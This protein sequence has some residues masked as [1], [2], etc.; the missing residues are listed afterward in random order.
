MTISLPSELE[1]LIE[2]RIQSGRYHSAVEVIVDALHLLR[3]RDEQDEQKRENLR[4]D[5][6]A[7]LEQIN[8]GK[9]GPLNA[10]ET[11]ARIRQE[12][13]SGCEG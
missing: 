7:G 5:L 9:V 8:Q 13:I 10:K 12:R 2:E 4:R 3:Q 1:Q 11:L 6:A